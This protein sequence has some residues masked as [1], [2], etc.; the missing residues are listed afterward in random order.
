MGCGRV[1]VAVC[2]NVL[3]VCWSVLECVVGCK[4]VGCARV[5]CEEGGCKRGGWHCAEL[6]G[7]KLECGCVAVCCSVLQCGVGCKRVG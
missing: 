5:G 4:R 3:G 2:C 7:E 1:C 6:R